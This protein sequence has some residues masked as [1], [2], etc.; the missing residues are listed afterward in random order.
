MK[1]LDGDSFTSGAKAD[2]SEHLNLAALKAEKER[3]NSEVLKPTDSLKL[4]AGSKPLAELPWNPNAQLDLVTGKS[5]VDFPMYLVAAGKAEPPQESHSM[6][7][8]FFSWG[9]TFDIEGKNGQKEGVVD[10]KLLNWTKT[11]EYS[12]AQGN[13]LATG[14]EALFSWGTRIDITDDK[15]QAIGTIKEDVLKSWWKT[16]TQYSIL[17]A[18]DKEVA[19]SEKVEWL[20]TDF[21]LKNNKGE[22]IATIHRPWFN[23]LRDNWTIDIQ[24]P[25]EV[26]KRILYMI[27][28]Y[29]TSVDYERKKEKEDE[30]NRKSKDKDDE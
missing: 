2:D 1:M 19:K 14:K 29:K 20:G 16:Y 8:R 30:E 10:Q 17:D 15:G 7:P 28:A 4:A 26:D 11:F 21:T 5:K 22:V 23:W 13:K 25:N 6:T 9:W 12:D 27:P 3:D 18:Q 24:K